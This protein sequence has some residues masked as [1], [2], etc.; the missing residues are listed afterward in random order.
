[1]PTTRKLRECAWKKL[2]IDVS[3]SLCFALLNVTF[4]IWYLEV[5]HSYVSNS[6]LLST[7][8]A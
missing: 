7:F 4:F 3:S 8:L 1:M 2:Y 5:I 6:F